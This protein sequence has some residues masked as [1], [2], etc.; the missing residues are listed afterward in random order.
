MSNNFIVPQMHF[1]DSE[2]IIDTS[3]PSKDDGV[4]CADDVLIAHYR[5][6]CEVIEE[7]ND[8]MIIG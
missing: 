8:R 7:F 1:I 6:I 4:R 5:N 3:K 2:L